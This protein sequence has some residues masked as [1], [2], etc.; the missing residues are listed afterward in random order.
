MIFMLMPGIEIHELSLIPGN[1]PVKKIQY[2]NAN[3]IRTHAVKS[4]IPEPYMDGIV[5]SKSID[6]AKSHDSTLKYHVYI[7]TGKGR[8]KKFETTE[9]NYKLLEK[10]YS[11][12][13]VLTGSKTYK[14]VHYQAPQ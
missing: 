12:H 1:H 7:R 3:N 13:Y 10:G 8:L 6:M 5:V 4:I 9:K 2:F 11:V 14:L